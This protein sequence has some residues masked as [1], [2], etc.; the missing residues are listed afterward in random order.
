MVRSETDP[1]QTEMPFAARQYPSKVKEHPAIYNAVRYLRSAGFYVRRQGKRHVV[2]DWQARNP[3]RHLDSDAL[4][5][6]A[7]G[8]ARAKGRKIE[9][10]TARI[11]PAPR[12]ASAISGA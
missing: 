8:H 4:R 12:G 11:R 10:A 2:I 9:D 6:F 5:R 7:A 3:T 1:R